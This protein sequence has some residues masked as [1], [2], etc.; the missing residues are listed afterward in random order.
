VTLDGLRHPIVLA[1]R[2]RDHVRERARR[3]AAG[4]S[5]ATPFVFFAAPNLALLLMGVLIALAVWLL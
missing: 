5:K 2:R 4:R 1:L 3:I